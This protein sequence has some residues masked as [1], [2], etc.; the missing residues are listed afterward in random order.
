LEHTEA[1]E[2]R[3]FDPT[4]LRRAFRAKGKAALPL[5]AKRGILC[6]MAG[7]WPD[8]CNLH[9]WGKVPE[10]PK[11]PL[12]HIKED[13]LHHRLWECR[14]RSPVHLNTALLHPEAIGGTAPPWL[15]QGLTLA[16]PPAA[17]PITEPRICGHAADGNIETLQMLRKD[18]PIYVD[19]SCTQPTLKYL[20]RAGTA[21]VQRRPRKATKR[22]T[23]ATKQRTSGQSK[24]QRCRSSR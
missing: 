3:R 5:G 1:L 12:C 8:G 17:V 21:L 22:P 13:S 9:K 20:A 16:P 6:M 19:G 2:G 15:Q 18:G 11:C 24:R 7:T 10:V 23:T 14:A 4:P